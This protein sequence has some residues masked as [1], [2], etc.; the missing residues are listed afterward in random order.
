MPLFGHHHKNEPDGFSGNI[1][2]GFT[3]LAEFGQAEGW[4]PVPGQPFDGHLETAVH[5]ITRAMYGAARTGHAVM[6]TGI[7]VGGTAFP[8]AFRAS[9]G[10][11]TVIVANAWTSIE[12]EVRYSTGDVRGVAVCAVEVPAVL[13]FLGIQS[14]RFPPIG[15]MRVTPTGDPGFDERF[16]VNA[17]P[18]AVPAVPSLDAVLTPEV[19]QRIMAHD[20]WVFWHERYLLGCVSPGVFRSAAEVSQ[21]IGEVLG[22][23]AAFPASAAPRQVD[24]SADDLMA[25][26]AAL[27]SMDEGMAFLTRLTPAD[28][29]QLA[30]S[31]SPL[32]VLADVR[33]PQEAM[34]RFRSLPQP[35]KMQLM[36]MFME[37]K[38][39]QRRR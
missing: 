17:V 3:G 27:K 23:V 4:E 37:V 33:T 21:R 1:P 15:L 35:Q 13:P 24:H 19:R 30:R 20:D 9:V 18:E 8:D 26:I 5:E 11:R 36:M 31:G 2:A 25:R 29:E 32:A 10:G 7:R 28:R 38:D 14:R 12:A 6:Q 39:Q 22:M 34:A 16:A